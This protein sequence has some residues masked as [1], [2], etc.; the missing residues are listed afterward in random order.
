[1]PRYL[2]HPRELVASDLGT[3]TPQVG[4]V[5]PADAYRGDPHKLTVTFGFVDLDHLEAGGVFRTAST[6]APLARASPSQAYCGYLAAIGEDVAAG[7]E[8]RYR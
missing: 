2:E 3:P 1:M 7:D 8:A 4:K 5:G 6:T